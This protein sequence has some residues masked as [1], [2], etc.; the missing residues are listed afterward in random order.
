MFELIKL[1]REEV[2]LGSWLE[3]LVHDPTNP[4]PLVL[5]QR[6]WMTIAGD[7]YRKKEQETI[8]KGT[9]LTSEDRVLLGGIP[10]PHLGILPVASKS[11]RNLLISELLVSELF[12]D[13]SQVQ[14]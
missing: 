12:Y 14:L 4:L 10:D 2:C 9:L 7:T 11:L 13:C 1:A 3:A 8:F 6:Y 5:W